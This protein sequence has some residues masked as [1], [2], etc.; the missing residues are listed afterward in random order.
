MSGQGDAG[1]AGASGD[2]VAQH[3][4][5]SEGPG[6]L[7]AA[8]IG[9]SADHPEATCEDCG[10]GNVTWFSPSDVWNAVCRPPGYAGDPMICPMC[11]MRRAEASGF[12]S[13]GWLVIPSDGDWG[14]VDRADMLTTAA[15][16]S[17]AALREEALRRGLILHSQAFSK[18]A[19]DVIRQCDKMVT[20]L[21]ALKQRA[22]NLPHA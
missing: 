12:G 7:R 4:R 11:F 10:L 20:E 22:E 18:A 1:K 17:D 19:A 9:I 13:V 8:P 14:P 2:S 3:G 5:A 6:A 16:M 21:K 15:A